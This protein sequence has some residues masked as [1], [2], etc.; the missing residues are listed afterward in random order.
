MIGLVQIAEKTGYLNQA[1]NEIATRYH[2][3]LNHDYE[4]LNKLIEPAIVLL[5]AM[6][7]GTLVI[8]LYWPI[9]N[10]GELF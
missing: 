7:T 2:L 10:L 3:K 8:A 1:F 9:F 4:K 6:I 5:I